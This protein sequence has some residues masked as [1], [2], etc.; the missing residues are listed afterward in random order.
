MD[1][2]DGEDDAHR[3]KRASETFP[4][5]DGGRQRDAEKAKKLLFA[6]DITRCESHRDH[7]DFDDRH[8]TYREYVEN[9]VCRGHV[10]DLSES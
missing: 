5:G 9:V 3:E 1:D 4:Y 10:T 8:H 6:D 2:D 7:A